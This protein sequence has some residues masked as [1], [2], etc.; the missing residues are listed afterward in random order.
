M[1]RGVSAYLFL[2]KSTLISLVLLVLR[3][4]LLLLHHSARCWTSSLYADSSF[5]LMSPTTVVSSANFPIVFEA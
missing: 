1:D 2:L 5:L 4:R 3:A